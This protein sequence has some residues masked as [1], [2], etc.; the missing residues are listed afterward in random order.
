M[1]IRMRNGGLGLTVS[2]LVHRRQKL[3]LPDE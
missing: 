3:I 2:A 1:R